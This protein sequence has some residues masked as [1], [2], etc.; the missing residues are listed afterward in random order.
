M[1]NKIESMEIEVFSTLRDIE[2]MLNRA[3]A[4]IGV[5]RC[6][7][8]PASTASIALRVSGKTAPLSG[9]KYVLDVY[10]WD[11][12]ETKTIEVC[13]HGS[14]AGTYFG[15]AFKAAFDMP[16]EQYIDFNCSRKKQREL[17]RICQHG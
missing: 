10:V 9:F 12:N 3:F 7:G 8:I 13:A 11:N 14:G 16:Y 4:K 6:E 1:S 5:E 15:S 17:L 2:R